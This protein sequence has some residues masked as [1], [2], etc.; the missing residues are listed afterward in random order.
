MDELNECHDGTGIGGYP[1][2][3]VSDVQMDKDM[4]MLQRAYNAES[5]DTSALRARHAG[6]QLLLKFAGTGNML[7]FGCSRFGC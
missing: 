3:L 4:V 5:H 7:A 1:M 2:G 6:T